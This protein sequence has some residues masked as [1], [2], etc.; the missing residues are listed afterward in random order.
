MLRNILAMVMIL[1]L[2]AALPVRAESAP[3]LPE[4][5]ASPGAFP[6]NQRYDVYEG[7]RDAHRRAGYGTAVVSTNGEIQVYGVWMGRMMIEYEI[8]DG[9]HR[10]GWI[11]TA[12]LP[13][14]ALEGVTELPF[15][16][17]GDPEDCTYGV[18][19]STTHLTDD[20]QH[21]RLTIGGII[22][23][24]TSVHVLASLGDW[25]L[26]EGFVNKELR[27]GFIRDT[28]LDLENGYSANPEWSIGHS[29]RYTEAD[30]IAAFD[31]L[32]RY[33]Y[34][35][36]PGTV[37]AA[38]RYDETAADEVDPNPWWTD[39]TGEFEGILLL[40]DLGSM[41]LWNCELAG[42]GVAQDYIFILYREPG[43]EWYVANGGYT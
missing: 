28:A 25:Y 31:A 23:V 39:E 27:M 17:G 5:T 24:G 4:L 33:I 42:Y 43:G 6:R 22:P 8:D 12:Q 35:S 29:T 14:S 13:P 37:L 41:E 10:I 15:P 36:W 3:A 21:S 32:G 11:D 19:T 1:S 40:A 16:T 18:T 26:V 20:P 38:V 34:L 2:L 30:V 9:R 7:P